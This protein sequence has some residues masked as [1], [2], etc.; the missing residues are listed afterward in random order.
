MNA[1]YNLGLNDIWR[2]DVEL[3]IDVQGMGSCQFSDQACITIYIPQQLIYYDQD[4]WWG[5]SSYLDPDLTTIPE[6]MD[7]LVVVPGSQYLI[8]MIN[9]GGGYFWPEPVPPTNTIGDWSPV[10]YKIKTKNG[11]SCLPIYGDTLTDQTFTVSGAFTFLPVLTNVPVNINALFGTH[12]NDIL[13][14]FDWPTGDLW[15]QVAS[16]FD[17]LMPGRAYLLVNKNPGMNYDIQFPNFDPLAPHLYPVAKDAVPNHSPWN[18]VTNTA[19]PHAILFAGEAMDELQIGDIIGVFDNKSDICFGMEEYLGPGTFFRLVAMGDNPYSK[20]KDGFI[21][22]QKMK[23]IL[24][25]QNTGEAFE[26]TFTYDKS[27]PN[28]DG[29]FHVNGVSMVTEMAMQMTGIEEMLGGNSIVVYPNP[30]DK[31]VNVSS[32]NEMKR[33]TLINHV[34]Q[35]IFTRE[36][37]GDHYQFDVSVFASGIYTVRIETGDN[38]III[39]R[40][41][42]R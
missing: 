32:T 22:G 41:S 33:I 25:R 10:G 36:V 4:T 31:L 30:S 2:G 1:V 13:L 15:T 27:Y 19:N 8:T 34:G 29:L 20:E 38:S 6:V 35:V 7:P 18:D 24:F 16:D 12:V 9:K 14:I 39:K 17:E 21:E 5:L 40:L 26:L 11:P 3:C 23:F 37:E 28:S 42:I